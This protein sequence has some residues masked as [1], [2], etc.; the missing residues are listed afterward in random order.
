MTTGAGSLN[1]DGEENDVAVPGVETGAGLETTGIGVMVG[2]V[3]G[4]VMPVAGVETAGIGIGAGT[5]FGGLNAA[6]TAPGFVP[7]GSGVLVKEA[8]LA[9]WLAGAAAGT[10]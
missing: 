1:P 4:S 7:V 5:E 10:P 9:G 6:G 3:A 8:G 2:V